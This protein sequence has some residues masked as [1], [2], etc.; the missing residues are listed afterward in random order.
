MPAY[1][2]V[3]RVVVFF[4]ILIVVSCGGGDDNAPAPPAAD[5][6]G[7]L[8]SATLSN[9]YTQPSLV[10]LAT[11]L[12]VFPANRVNL[13]YNVEV[14]ELVYWT[15]DASGNL[16]QASGLISVPQ[17]AAGTTTPLLSFQHGT[18]FHDS[19]APTNNDYYDIVSAML[20]SMDFIVTTPDYIGYG[21]SATLLHPY[22]HAESTSKATV[23]L[24]RAAKQWL[25]QN[26]IA[27]NDQLFLAGYSEGG[28]ATL[29]THKTVQEQYSSEFTVTASSPGAGPYDLLTTAN[30]YL[31]STN[32]PYAPYIGFIFKAYDDVYAYNRIGDIFQAAYVTP[33]DNYYYG[34]YTGA[35]IDAAL[36][37]VT[38]NLF[39]ATFLSNFLGA[40]ETQIKADLMANNLYDWRP[41]A[42]VRL[43]HGME[44][45]D[46]PY[47]NATTTVTTMQSNGA[48]NVVL[49][50]CPVTPATHGN[51][52][53]PYLE[54]MVNY[55]LSF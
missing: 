35:Q 43:F 28:Y 40:G 15:R 44:D 19:E 31:S 26:N 34:A 13:T 1:I 4:L 39:E 50:D 47:A 48:T 7:D 36:T 2:W 14:Y 32:L 10:S 12:N 8:V 9:S 21:A 54:D 51:C 16:V 29:A 23:D 53:N 41:D 3:K 5:Q 37:N 24:L 27:I 18:V 22:L 42:P 45:I 17:K 46:V 11:L 49:V 20:A 25:S 52:A 33:I 55:F 6:R 30:T 38:A